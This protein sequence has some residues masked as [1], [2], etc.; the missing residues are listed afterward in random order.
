[1]AEDVRHDGRAAGDQQV[2][3]AGVH[4]LR[5][6]RPDHLSA[7]GHTGGQRLPNRYGARQRA[8]TRRVCWSSTR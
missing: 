7:D 1:M 6:R 8:S 4:R 5:R 2:A 3:T